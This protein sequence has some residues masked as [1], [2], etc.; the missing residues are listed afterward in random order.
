MHG[1]LPSLLQVLF[2]LPPKVFMYS[3]LII[4]FTFI[5]LAWKML[6]CCVC[7]RKEVML[8]FIREKDKEPACLCYPFNDSEMY[9]F[10]YVTLKTMVLDSLVT[11]IY[12][13]LPRANFI[14]SP[15]FLPLPCDP[16]FYLVSDPP[17]FRCLN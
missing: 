11:S 5:N 10:F 15:A 16:T 9:I 4:L 14:L 13:N 2:S 7:L 1:F 12:I 6:L 17:N 3:V 8:L